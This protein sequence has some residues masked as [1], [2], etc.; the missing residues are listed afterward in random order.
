MSSQTHVGG[1]CKQSSSGSSSAVERMHSIRDFCVPI[2][3]K[4]KDDNDARLAAAAKKRKHHSDEEQ[5][6]QRRGSLGRQYTLPLPPVA[7]D[8]QAELRRCDYP[9]NFLR[10]AYRQPSQPLDAVEFMI[11]DMDTS[12]EITAL[13]DVER[14]YKGRDE[15]RE[16]HWSFY[17]RLFGVTEQGHSVSC[18]LAGW[19][20]YLYVQIPE[21]W[22]DVHVQNW[23]ADLETK[24]KL[25]SLSRSLVAYSFERRI[26]IFGYTKGTTIPVLKM[27]FANGGAKYNVSKLLAAVKDEADGQIKHQYVWNRFPNHRFWLWDGAVDNLQ[28]FI[29][30][31]GIAPS[32]WMRVE[33]RDYQFHQSAS[34][35]AR[36]RRTRCQIDINSTYGAVQVL[37]GR[38]DI[39]P[40]LVESWDIEV[41]RGARD[42]KFPNAAVD[43]D[44][45]FQ[46]GTSVM[47]FGDQHDAIPY[48]SAVHCVRPTDNL[49]PDSMHVN[50]YKDEA[51]MLRD[52]AI[53]TRDK[54]DADI[55]VDFNGKG[56]DRKYWEDRAARHFTNAHCDRSVAYKYSSYEK[57][58]FE[59]G[60]VRGKLSECQEKYGG[61]RAHGSR[62]ENS[63]EMIGRAQLDL[64]QWSSE[65]W[66]MPRSLND[67]AEHIYEEAKKGKVPLRKDDFVKIDLPFYVL[68]EKYVGTS[69]DRAEVAVYCAVDT[70]V[71]LRILDVKKVLMGVIEISRLTGITI[72][73]V[74][75]KKQM[76]R[77]FAKLS[78]YAHDR[79]YMLPEFPERFVQDP[80]LRDMMFGEGSYEGATVIEPERGF[81][82]TNVG[83]LDFAGLY[84]SIMRGYGLCYTTL[85]LDKKW[86]ADAETEHIKITIRN[87][88]PEKEPFDLYWCTNWSPLLYGLLTEI[89]DAR[90]AAKALKKQH[91]DDQ[92]LSELYEARQLGLKLIANSTYGFCGAKVGKLPNLAIAAAV[93]HFGRE[94][95]ETTARIVEEQEPKCKVI[96]GDSVTGDTPVYLRVAG[97]LHI[98]RFDHVSSLLGVDWCPFGLGDKE[99]LE[100]SA[101][102]VSVWNDGGFA[103]VTR[104]IR[105][106]LAPGKRMMR[107]LT[108]TGVVDVTEDHSLL[109]ED[110]SVL[111]ANDLIVGRTRLLS[112]PD[113]TALLALLETASS[114]D[115]QSDS[116]T[117][118]SDDVETAFAWGM[119]LAEGSC[120]LYHCAGGKKASWAISNQNRQL[121]ERCSA[122]LPFPTRIYDCSESSNCFKLCISF[123]GQGQ[124]VRRKIIAIVKQYRAMFYNAAGEKK[125]PSAIMS[126][127]LATVQAFVD[128]FHAGDGDFGGQYRRFS[129]R[130]KQA[131]SML[132]LLYRRLG[133]LVSINARHDKLDVLRMTLTKQKQRKTTNVVK[134]VFELDT[135]A[136]DLVYD[137]ETASGHFHVGPG[138]LVVHNTDSVMIKFPSDWSDEQ[139]FAVSYRLADFITDAIGR[140]EV[141]LEFE[142]IYKGYLLIGKKNYAGLKITRLGE[143]PVYATKGIASVRGDKIGF[144]K[145]NTDNIVKC[146]LYD[147]SEQ[148]AIQLLK[149]EMQKLVD[150]QIDPS[151]LMQEKKLT[152]ALHEYPPNVIHVRVAREM[153][154]RDP[155]TAPKA[156]E[157]V[158]FVV[159]QGKDKVNPVDFKHFMANRDKYKLDIPY[160][161]ENLCADSLG[162]LLDFKEICDD[163]FRFFEPYLAKANADK[164]GVQ[165]ITSFLKMSEVDT[166]QFV[167]ATG[168][169]RS[170]TKRKK[171]HDQERAKKHLKEEAKRRGVT[172][173]SLQ[174]KSAPSIMKFLK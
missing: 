116:L 126:A 123:G 111:T 72:N 56:F 160:Y 85:I 152:K 36:E 58:K 114:V 96:Y 11:T 113:D 27:E 135:A 118:T 131:C 42:R 168:V 171:Q 54:V 81:H 82:N 153:Q 133:F 97:V 34:V 105:H 19:K 63:M 154:K 115:Q 101:L 78:K 53:F 138:N 149:D 92:F 3:S 148:K 67:V 73:D 26:N 89:L 30:S 75:N 38:D 174:N 99:S 45:I 23:I 107:V 146:L 93:T 139:C 173:A 18:Y 12:N 41:M 51:D 95:I 50:E 144:V 124:T 104:F 121:L 8:Y 60:R 87:Q 163:P 141:Q 10:P 166:S 128:G 162:K 16:D 120:G 94:L 21:R 68:H 136:I 4:D 77:T 14:K 88:D 59:Y 109:Q 64:F 49:R 15:V 43:G 125:I 44:E 110:G 28:Q 130:G 70:Q 17:V 142:K 39:P 5:A 9:D 150:G 40:L 80:H 90:A 1:G 46:I 157:M 62:E 24:P 32:T 151:E 103:R 143:E 84:P 57:G 7:D 145:R 132:W 66:G 122:A 165:Q 52:Y 29:N 61:S 112:E 86:L 156:G 167:R 98:V 31:T 25:A 102:D 106:R 134:R 74:I 129:Q 83:T 76:A 35:L 79:N 33:K 172:V 140:K 47:R 20:P 158:G 91:A 161:I 147:R 117:D 37:G 2:E 13:W 170:V 65:E 137:I 119:F 155:G 159:V 71:P 164:M 48:Y 127:P 69:Y 22:N 55:R 6:R 108:H 100:M 169:K